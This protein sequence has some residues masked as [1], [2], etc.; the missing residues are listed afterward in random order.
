MKTLVILVISLCISFFANAQTDSLAKYF[1]ISMEELLSLKITTAGK[2]EQQVKDIPASVVVITRADIEAHGYRSLPEILEN[3]PG[4][5]QINDY[6]MGVGGPNFGVRG[7]WSVIPNDDIMFLVND[8]DQVDLPYSA[9][10]LTKITLPVEAIE[11]IEVIRGPMSVLYGSGA[12]FGVVNIFTRNVNPSETTTNLVS[13]SLGT[14]QTGKAVLRVSGNSDDFNYSINASAY[15]S[16]GIDQPYSLM[17]ENTSIFKTSSTEGL[18]EQQEFYLG[19]NGEF[20]HFY[21]DFTYNESNHGLMFLLPSAGDGSASTERATRFALGY[22]NK[23][24]DKWLL[25]SRLSYYSSYR[26]SNYDHFYQNTYEIQDVPSTGYD[27]DLS[28]NSYLTEQF[29]LTAGAKFRSILSVENNLHLPTTGF[30]IFY[31]TTQTIDENDNINS[32]AGFMQFDYKPGEK[33]QFVLGGRIEQQLEFTLKTI[34]ADTTIGMP[35]NVFLDEYSQK[36][37]QFIPRTAIIYSFTD[38]HIVKLLYG[39]A[40]NT[41]SWFQIH[42]A[43]AYRLDLRPEEIQSF[44]INYIAIPFPKLLINTSFFYNRMNN[45]IVRTLGVNDQ[46]Q[47]YNYNS[48]A[49]K[50]ETKGMELTLQIKPVENL[51]VEIS[52]TYQKSTDLDNKEIAYNY[53]P[54]LL[55]NLKVSYRINQHLNASIIANYVDEMETNWLSNP[56]GTGSRIGEPVPA[57]FMLG[58]N[59]RLIRLV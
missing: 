1:D 46:G 37:I 49:G 35:A 25:D 9:Y 18:L 58:A 48:N 56:D 30:G 55:G 27:L 42:N 52:S 24:S 3:I 8:V 57:Y 32:W 11:R 44:E 40:V 15:K 12:F 17:N 13:S 38:N 20:K 47:F 43:G 23:M 22:K 45:L 41:P 19:F 14:Q 39:K 50:V 33:L 7:Y 29:H 53:S 59:I 21:T 34:V 28:V 31:N 16:S 5:Y 26:K 4:M 36:E 10:D 6:S 2:K 54:N 51:D